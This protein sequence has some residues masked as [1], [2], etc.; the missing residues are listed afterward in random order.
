MYTGDSAFRPNV[1]LDAALAEA[2][3]QFVAANPESHERYDRARRSIA[4]GVSRSALHYG[5]FP[6]VFDHG[7]GQFIWDVDGHE[8]LDAMGDYTAGIFGH[9]HPRVRQAIL[10]AFDNGIAL[11]GPHRFEAPFA[12]VL[13]ERIP[14][15]EKMRFCSS[16]TEAN[17][18]ALSL[19]RVATGRDAFMAFDGSYHGGV[20]NFAKADMPFN[21][22]ANWVMA[23]FNDIDAT[24]ALV[25]AHASDLA[26]ILVEPMI[27]AGGCIP[28]ETAFLQALRE[29][30]TAHDIVL[31]FD[32]VM[33]SRLGPQGMQGRVGVI[34][35]MT[36]VSKFLGG[37]MTFGAFG[38]RADL[39]DRFDPEYEDALPLAGTFSNNVLTMEAGRVALSEIYTA[40]AADDLNARG[41]RLR[42]RFN[43]CAEAHD[44]AVRFI[45]IG[46]MM[47][48]HFTREAVRSPRQNALTDPRKRALLHLDLIAAGVFT[49]R[50]GMFVLS[51]PMTDAD[52]DRLVET[53]ADCLA[54]R[55]SLFAD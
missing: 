9:N 1:D 15:F 33:T 47:N 17:L 23:P 31:I 28:A 12:E 7:D 21:F 8:Y 20:F 14:S 10:D 11:N 27:G 42:E 6:L 35:D 18:F 45:G 5:P 53:V 55:R 22:P 40:A 41:D 24:R 43:E 16:G 50:S 51:L 3:A 38:G 39:M 37:G 48:P 25:E 30:A 34:P 52:L 32:E 36:S 19:A 46:S 2:E 4:G 26:A 29:M 13:C 44:V 49:A 54:S